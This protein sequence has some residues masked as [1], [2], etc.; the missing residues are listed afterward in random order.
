M[1]IGIRKKGDI[2]VLTMKG[3]IRPENWRTIDRH[4]QAILEKGCRNLVVDMSGIT[5]LCGIGIIALLNCAGKLRERQG[6]LLLL[7]ETPYALQLLESAPA[8][9][10]PAGNIFTDRQKLE[11]RLEAGKSSAPG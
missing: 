9:S 11:Q 5:L 2:H 1:Q 10:L 3:K 7:A 6:S 4:I 8:G